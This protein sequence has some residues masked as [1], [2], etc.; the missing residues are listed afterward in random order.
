MNEH[1]DFDQFS[2]QNA[3]Q[4]VLGALMSRNEVLDDLSFLK[5]EHF[6]DDANRLIFNVIC[7]QIAH[8][9]TSDPISIFDALQSANRLGEV[10]GMEYINALAT[11]VAGGYAAKHWAQILVDKHQLRAVRNM[12]VA[13]NEAV[14]KRGMSGEEAV[15][16]A[17]RSLMALE[18]SHEEQVHDGVSLAN[19]VLAD[20]QKRFD[21]HADDGMK[22][23]FSVLDSD[24]LP[25]GIERGQL[26][27][28][29]GSGS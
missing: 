6:A 16:E 29:A 8:G 19:E 9:K 22:T 1:N 7:K 23:G 21:G 17:M 25:N 4:S 10:G 24:V 15:E 28:I 5:Q 26:V 20:V 14:C 27:V 12:A 18:Q 13:L 2:S 11:S 3:E